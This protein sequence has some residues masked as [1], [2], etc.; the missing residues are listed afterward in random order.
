[1]SLRTGVEMISLSMLFNKVAGF[2]GLLAILT[3]FHLDVMQLSLYLYSVVALVLLAF[4]MPHV[5][6]QSPFECLAL[7]WFYLLDT[8]VNCT[9]TAA[10]AFT[11]FM[12]ISA[13][14]SDT[15]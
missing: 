3:G 13:S 12:T 2:Y 5:R 15:K 9:Y 8:I 4:L 14:S 6:K 1:M 7:S 11:W 10:F